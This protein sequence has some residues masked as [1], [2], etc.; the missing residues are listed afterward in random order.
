MTNLF[1]VD[2]EETEKAMKKLEETK[3]SDI[4]RI[5]ERHE[6]LNNLL[7]SL[8]KDINENESTASDFKVED[9]NHDNIMAD[10][11]EIGRELDILLED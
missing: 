5:N 8:Q 2:F 9:Y 11:D 4:T 7:S 1:D 3:D 10:L 6:E